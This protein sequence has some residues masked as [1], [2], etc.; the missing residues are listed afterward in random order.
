MKAF[1]LPDESGSATFADIPVPDPGTGE[2]R[3]AVKASSVNGW[4]TF[5]ASGMARSFMDHRYP[6]VIGKDLAGVVDAVGEGVDRFAVGD[7]VTGLTPV[8]FPLGRGTYAGFVV[9]PAE[10]FTEPKPAALTFE[11]A[12]SVGMAALTALVSADAADASDG[13]VILIA[14]ATGGV[15]SYTVQIAARRGAHVI[16]TSLP[17]DDGWIRSLGASEVVDYRS[18]VAGAVRAAHPD[19]IDALID[20]VNRGDAHGALTRVVKRGGHVVSTNAAVDAE[21]LE[22]LGV[23]GTSVVAQIDPAPFARVLRMVADGGLQ[24]PIRRTFSF[25][26]IPEALGLVGTR[27]S[28]GKFA[29][30]V[31]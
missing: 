5:V 17:D 22:D 18:D 3:V 29:I 14:G 4:D 7:E 19:G 21:A 6:V 9:V 13:S 25:E 28:R 24:V 10:G 31:G 11:Q 20:A 30:R 8:E 16:A 26:E 12:G 2:I 23:T 1:V 15:G 27:S